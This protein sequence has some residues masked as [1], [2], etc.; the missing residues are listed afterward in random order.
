MNEIDEAPVVEVSQRAAKGGEKCRKGGK[1]RGQWAS[2]K[3]GSPKD[4]EL[5]ARA[6]ALVQAGRSVRAAADATGLAERRLQ[7]VAS[8]EGWVREKLAQAERVAA[9]G[10]R[11]ADEAEAY[12]VRA[13]HK[14]L[15]WFTHLEQLPADE[16]HKAIDTFTKLDK[17]M[18]GTLGLDIGGSAGQVN[19]AVVTGWN[20]GGR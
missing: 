19:I 16:L 9:A 4:L 2:L 18:R 6:K 8:K 20:G 14:L 10:I 7:R 15:E 13:Y 1:A 11:W 17:A 12:R 3:S 5:V